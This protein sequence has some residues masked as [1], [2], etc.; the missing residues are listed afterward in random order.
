M[1]IVPNTW[2]FQEINGMTMCVM[3]WMAKRN[4]D[5]TQEIWI[6]G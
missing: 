5:I 3:Q 4:M 2:I 6:R 1:L